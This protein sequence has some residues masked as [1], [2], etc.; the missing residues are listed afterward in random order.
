MKVVFVTLYDE[1]ARGA[2]YVASAVQAAGHQVAFIHFKA[3]RPRTIPRRDAGQLAWA[4]AQGPYQLREIT[5]HG[6]RFH[7]YPSAITDLERRKLAELIDRHKPGVIGL[8]FGTHAFPRAVEVTGLLRAARPGVPIVWGGVHA[9]IDP[10]S[11]IPHADVVCVG[12]GEEA[13]VE[14]LRDPKRTDIVGLWFR[15]PTGIIRNPL[16]PLIQDLDALVWPV[17]AADEY[18]V[19]ENGIERR[20]VEES[21]YIACNFYSETTRGCPFHCTYCVHSTTRGL[22][23]GQR[24]VRPRS[25]ESVIA[26]IRQFRQRFGLQA[27]MPFFDEILFMNKKRFAHFAQLYKHEIGH[28]FWGFAHPNTTDRE[29]L[30]IARDAGSVEISVGIQTG[31]ER[32]ARDIYRRPIDREAIVRLTHDIRET[33]AGRLVLNVLADCPFEEEEDLRATFDLLIQIPRPFVLQ[34]S[35]VVPFPNTALAKMRCDTPPLPAHVRDFWH[36]L[37]LLTQSDRVDLTTLRGLAEDHHLREN[38][39]ALAEMAAKTLPNADC[40]VSPD[41]CAGQ[42]TAPAAPAGGNGLLR[43]VYRKFRNSLAG[44]TRSAGGS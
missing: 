26:E 39:D 7:P 29:M 1:S 18:Q 35:R 8:S 40:D 44:L 36:S 41:V 34:L 15:T 28:P 11:S 10:E 20:I 19:N 16:R 6:E 2:R 5:A 27:V 43:R 13:F 3:F 21:A 31:S 32:I 14:Y 37:F 12:E 22:Y 33:G 25:S 42:T 24:Y 30:E 9:T 38:P 17:Y 4:A 23:A